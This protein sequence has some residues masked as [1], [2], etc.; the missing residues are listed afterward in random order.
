MSHEKQIF[1]YFS[2]IERQQA[3]I[4]QHKGFLQV[5]HVIEESWLHLSEG[6]KGLLRTEEEKG[7]KSEKMTGL[8]FTATDTWSQGL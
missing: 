1:L 6:K 5:G 7:W 8:Y 2:A 4:T 3:T